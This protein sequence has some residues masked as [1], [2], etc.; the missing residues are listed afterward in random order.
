MST[1]MTPRSIVWEIF[2]RHMK[3][4]LKAVK[5]AWIPLQAY[6]KPIFNQNDYC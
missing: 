2:P 1:L 3:L 6:Y 4:R 5:G